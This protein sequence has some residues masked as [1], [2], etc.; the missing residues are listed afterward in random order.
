[1][2]GTLAQLNSSI[3][4]LLILIALLG[5]GW[6]LRSRTRAR[7]GPF[8]NIFCIIAAFGLW[9][10]LARKHGLL[11]GWN[12]DSFLKWYSA[13][14]IFFAGWYLA[15]IFSA[16]FWDYY[17][18]ERRKTL[19]PALLRNVIT[20][21]ILIASVLIIVRFIFN[22][23]L[24]GLLVT[25]SVMAAILA[26]ALQDFLSGIIAGIALNI[27]PPFQVG[28]WVMFG[29]KEGEVVDINW[30]A[31]TIRTLDTTY[32]VIPNSLISK[33]QI[34]NFYRPAKLHA[35]HRYVGVEYDAPPTRV[36]DILITCALETQGVV[37]IPRPICRLIQFGDFSI[38]Y[39]L[40]FWIE[41]HSKYQDIQ[42]D[43]M[44]RIWY[45]LRRGGIKMPFPIR[46]VFMHEGAVKEKVLDEMNRQRIEGF[47]RRVSIF[48][49]LDETAIK[50][51]ALSGHFLHFEKRERI[52]KQGDTGSSLFLILHGSAGV[53]IK[54]QDNGT[55]MAV[56]HLRAGDFFGERSLLTGEPRSACVIA[57]T[58][59][60]VIEIEK[61]SILSMLE[62]NPGIIEELS[63]R[64]AE[65]QLVNEGFFK[66]QKK[67][68]EVA[69][70]RKNY[71]ERFLK[72]MRAFFGL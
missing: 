4:S 37:S 49:P 12:L 26:F 52:V 67:A 29:D 63:R 42:A 51:L 14:V 38:T 44:A 68:E 45:N 62:T 54:T 6:L 48:E 13:V 71:T 25:S 58:D 9:L 61:A 69:V 27:E 47:L 8:Y 66:E 17:L 46:D 41:D 70:M 20:V 22:Q 50:A 39:E 56:G 18:F 65:R 19:V 1:M 30:R 53:Y 55:E 16:F 2:A 3:I 43:V 40:K 57:E 36:K 24:S 59:I 15:R 72:S 7:F 35:L 60:E 23:P 33:D 31:T 21:L 34:I 64:L 11:K 5:L 28:D 10:I 32:V